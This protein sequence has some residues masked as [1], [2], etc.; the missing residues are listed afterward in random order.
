MDGAAPQSSDDT[1]A[2]SPWTWKNYTAAWS[3]LPAGDS[4]LG[5]SAPHPPLTHLMRNRETVT[6][7]LLQNP[8]SVPIDD[9]KGRKSAELVSP[10]P[11]LPQ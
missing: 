11:S 4:G 1:T 6:A 5:G 8:E 7:E 2:H 9:E 10:S 3:W